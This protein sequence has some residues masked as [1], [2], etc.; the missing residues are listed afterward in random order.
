MQGPVVAGLVPEMN[1]ESINKADSDARK[2]F[3]YFPDGAVDNWRSHADE[4]LAGK[5]WNGDCD[6][7]AST[8]LDLLGRQHVPLEDR[9][10]LL[11]TTK[12][13]KTPDHM[14]ACVRT[15]EGEFRIVGDTFRSA[16]DVRAMSHKS[17][18]YNRLSENDPKT[19]WR[20]G[21]PWK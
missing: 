14:I 18:F 1:A 6:D 17:L 12:G 4:V 7:L 5:S 2:R 16:Y 10:R 19:V 3:T 8:V 11:V 9:Y 13:A 15:D 20:E 21:A